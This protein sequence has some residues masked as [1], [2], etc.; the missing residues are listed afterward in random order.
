VPPG[1]A[2]AAV[3]TTGYLGF[4]AGPP[5]IGVVAEAAGLAVGL[6]LVSG[7]CAFVALKA[8]ALPEASTLG[9]S[10]TKGTHVGRAGS[11]FRARVSPCKALAS[12]A[13]PSPLKTTA[14]LTTISHWP[15]ECTVPHIEAP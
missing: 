1:Q 3:A 6:G 4:L 9:S 13:S 10:A 8:G 7:A 14:A 12:V 11:V 2:L 5:L 15:P